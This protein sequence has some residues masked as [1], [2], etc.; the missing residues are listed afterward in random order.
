MNTPRRM[1]MSPGSSL[2]VGW[3]E[4]GEGR[5]AGSSEAIT[6]DQRA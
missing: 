6:I 1:T 3:G 4:E 5:G 2:G